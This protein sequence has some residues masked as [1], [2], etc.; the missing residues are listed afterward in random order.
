MSDKQQIAKDNLDSIRDGFE[1]WLRGSNPETGL[2]MHRSVVERWARL[3]DV[4]LEEFVGP[5][6]ET[7]EIEDPKYD[8]ALSLLRQYEM[9]EP[10]S[11][12]EDG[13]K[14]DGAGP[15][16]WTRLSTDFAIHFPTGV[17][18]DIDANLPVYTRDYLKLE[19]EE[20]AARLAESEEQ[21]KKAFEH[22]GEDLK[23]PDTRESTIKNRST[24]IE[25]RQFFGDGRVA[26]QYGSGLIQ[27]RREVD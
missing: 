22:E 9:R 13:V 21:R 3:L 15:Q 18:W 16:G 19:A 25:S 27:E 2:W 26:V 12:D 17:E 23:V 8:E 10:P 24:Q 11:L 4:A 14:T 6:D 1:S 7:I 5:Q 20:T